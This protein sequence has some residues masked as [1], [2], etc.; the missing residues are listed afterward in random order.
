MSLDHRHHALQEVTDRAVLIHSKHNKFSNTAL[1]LLLFRL[2]THLS[3]NSFLL[4]GR[5]FEV[6]AL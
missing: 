1:C 2:L 4:Q 3:S 6:S 5:L